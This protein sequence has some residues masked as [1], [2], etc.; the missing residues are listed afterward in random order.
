[1]IFRDLVQQM[2]VLLEHND[3]DHSPGLR[4]LHSRIL[5]N[6]IKYIRETLDK[7]FEKTCVT[8]RL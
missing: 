5:E 6:R 2:I 4:Q 1:M 8:N 3:I 7:D